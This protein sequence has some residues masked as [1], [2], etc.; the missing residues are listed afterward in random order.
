MRTAALLASWRWRGSWRATAGLLVLAGVTAAVPL[1]LWTAARQTATAASRFVESADVA[2]ATVM[3]CP[4]G[5]D[6]EAEGDPGPCFGYQADAET[7]AMRELPQVDE[8]TALSF[9]PL[10]VEVPG[11]GGPS[12]SLGMSILRDEASRAT[13]MGDPVVTSGRLFRAGAHDE[14][15][16]IEAAADELGIS[17]GDELVV[18]PPEGGGVAGAALTVVGIVRTPADLL[19]IGL[20]SLAGPAFYARSSVQVAL[21]DFPAFAAPTVWLEDGDVDG[22]VDRLRERL[23]GQYVRADPALAPGDLANIQQ[24]TDLES[25]A[26]LATAGVAAVVAVFFVGQAL[27]R[28]ARAESSGEDVLLALG[29]TR[30]QQVVVALLRWLPVA[31]AAAVVAVILTVLAS[32]LG[33]VGVARRAPWDGGLRGDG[34]VLGVGITAVIFSVTTIAVSGA[35]RAARRRLDTSPSTPAPVPPGPPGLTTGIALTWRSLRGGAALPL[36]SAIAATA[37]ALALVIA[38]AGAAAS[39]RR[40]TDE[41]ARYGVPWDAL[42]SAGPGQ[43][44]EARVAG[45]RGVV[46]A[47]MIAG[48]DAGIGTDGQVWTQAILP[49]RDI[50]RTPPVI[51]DGREPVAEDEIALG[52]LTMRDADAAIGDEITVEAPGGDRP[53]RYRVVGAAMVTD[54]YE[55]NVGRG[56]TVTPAGLERLDPSAV[57]S[58]AELGLQVVEGPGRDEALTAVAEAFPLAVTPFPVPASVA[59]AERILGLPLFLAVGGAAL[60]AITLTHALVMSA[61]RNRRELSVLR[62]LGFTAGQ[63]RTALGTQASLLGVAAIVPGVVLGLIAARWGWRA[64]AGSFGLVSG[65]LVPL[66]VVLVGAGAA[67]AVANL[68]AAAPGRRHTRLG[69]ADALR[70]E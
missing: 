36:A 69:L 3:V 43:D 29:V 62:V 34:L 61:R 55:P 27:S 58:G 35:V 51:V 19:P 31:G 70:A 15:V 14:V 56:A 32:L 42:V 25:R 28:H 50:A 67:L 22:F 59:N 60:A 65:P 47:G 4:R 66:W 21:G 52:S 24:A 53:L 18:R 23:G 12:R 11:T 5:Y 63:V 10:D 26:A 68:A 30:R 39:L 7:Q 17:V 54:G 9:L 13:A 64:V 16:A 38:A 1:A 40:V 45:V 46:A 20:E 44:L 33:P 57:A 6:P 37:L 48:T 41:P 8:V 2:D 49:L